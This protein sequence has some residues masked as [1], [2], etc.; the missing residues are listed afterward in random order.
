MYSRVIIV[1][2]CWLG[3]GNYYD[4]FYRRIKIGVLAVK[5]LLDEGCI[6][7]DRVEKTF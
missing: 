3:N 1:R 5:G 7:A 2:G 6:D 4:D